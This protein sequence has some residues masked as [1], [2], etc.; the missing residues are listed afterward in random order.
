MH[1]ELSQKRLIPLH[2]SALQTCGFILLKADSSHGANHLWLLLS[3][4]TRGGKREVWKNP[5]CENVL[6]KLLKEVDLSI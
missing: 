6:R 2:A 5:G 1:V 3:P 4:R